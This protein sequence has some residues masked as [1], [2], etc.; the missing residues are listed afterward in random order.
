M[1][2]PRTRLVK[3]AEAA[4]GTMSVHFEKPAGFEYR[5]GQFADDTLL[6]PAETD[7]EGNIR[8]F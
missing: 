3:K 4:A 6:S 2:R 1:A 5:T 8:G 7:D